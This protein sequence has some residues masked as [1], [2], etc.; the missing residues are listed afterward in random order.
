MANNVPIKVEW[1]G[2][3]YTAYKN[4]LRHDGCIAYMSETY[5][6]LDCPE[7]WSNDNKYLVPCSKCWWVPFYKVKII[8]TKLKYRN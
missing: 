6:L 4:V 3:V 7:G 5:Y 8:P 1:K 2:I